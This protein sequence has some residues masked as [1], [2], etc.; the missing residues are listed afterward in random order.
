MSAREDIA[1]AASSVPGCTVT[2]YYRQTMTP[3]QGCVRFAQAVP[4][5]N[6]FGYVHTMQVWLALS[7]DIAT[8]EQWT[9]DNLPA[10]LDALKREWH[11]TSVTFIDSLP[12]ANGVPALVIEGTRAAG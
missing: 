11:T 5:S 12:G 10:L 7:Q 4:G 8:A 1:T 2:P 3:G 9:E 6:G